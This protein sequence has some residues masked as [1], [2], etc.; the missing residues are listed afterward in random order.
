MFH[1]CHED[2]TRVTIPC[3]GPNSHKHKICL[4]KDV[5]AKACDGA[6]ELYLAL[7]QDLFFK[8]TKDTTASALNGA[9]K[10]KVPEVL[11]EPNE[12]RV[13]TTPLSP[14][15]SEEERDEGIYEV[16]NSFLK[17]IRGA[18]N[19][20]PRSDLPQKKVEDSNSKPRPATFSRGSRLPTSLEP[21]FFIEAPLEGI[22]RR[23]DS[24]GPKLVEIYNDDEN[25]DNN[26]YSSYSRKAKKLFPS[27]DK[28][29]PG[30]HP[31]RRK[32]TVGDQHFNQ[33]RPYAI[34]YAKVPDT[35]LPGSISG[36][37][38]VPRI[39]QVLKNPFKLLI[40]IN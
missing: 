36:F 15:D 27:S 5:A 28:K 3:G 40:C 8:G 37:Q 6:T 20:Q 14:Y 7:P 29:T 12:G 25:T 34:I 24:G 23:L 31:R 9:T 10:Y 35:T 26:D 13:S 18:G 2:G 33:G 19:P 17:E 22:G 39:T 4:L 16:F 11:P 38:N 30:K 1:F 32:R 21:E